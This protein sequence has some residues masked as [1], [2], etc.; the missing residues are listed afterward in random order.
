MLTHRLAKNKGYTYIATPLTIA[1][2]VLAGI[3]SL[4]GNA[5]AAA[6]S[7]PATDYGKLTTSLTVPSTTTYRIWSR[8]MPPDSTNH[9]YLLQV[10]G[11]TCYTVGGAALTANSWTWVDYQSGSNTNKIQ[12]SLA[13]GSHTLVLIGNAP[14]VKV[15]RIIAVS[16]T[17]CVPTGTGDN[18]NT[19]SDTAPPAVTLTAP[20]EGSSVSGSVSLTASASDS[21]GVTKVEFYD[22]TSLIATDT[23]AP[24]SATWDSSKVPNGSHLVT[25]RAYDA[26]GNLSS[27][28]HTVTTRNGDTQAPSAPSGLTASS[29]SYSTVAL[30]W[31][32]S[33]DNTAVTGYNIIRDGVP[34]AKVG[35]VTSYTD[36]SLSANTAYSYSVQAFDAAGNVST[37][38]A[39]ISTTTKNVAD[40]TPPTAATNLGATAVSQSQI[41]LTWAAGT[42]NIGI[43]SYTV[44]RSTGSADPQAIGTSTTTSFGDPGLAASTTYAYYVVAKDASGNLSPPSATVTAQTAAAPAPNTQS[45][46]QGTI[47]D[48]ATGKPIPYASVVIVVNAHRN[49]YQADQYGRYAVLQLP[50]GR[51]N[52]T[53][54]AKYYYSKTV[55]VS[56]TS[57]PLA[58]DMSL[59]KR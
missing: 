28:A 37:A 5:A 41:N 54:R 27:D 51:Y 23:S 42:D 22:N 16:D 46:I 24:Y 58:Q 47:T 18:C 21:V 35:A 32:A 9:S 15:D 26:A 39:K 10:D 56:L 43:V 2:L 44:Y 57:T 25:A 33:T 12:Q 49:I 36:T 34:V 7:T 13:Q 40:S 45:S 52:L 31:K 19:P 20:A 29:P 48:Q 30:S 59:K 14:G 6:C 8:I 50:T 3:A 17:S 38:S 55:S 11:S 53:F 4:T 1:A